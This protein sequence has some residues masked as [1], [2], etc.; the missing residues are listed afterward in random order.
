MQDGN[1]SGTVEVQASLL[2]LHDPTAPSIALPVQTPSAAPAPRKPPAR[3]PPREQK[4]PAST[5]TAMSALAGAFR[6][7][8]FY[9][10]P[11]PTTVLGHPN[12]AEY[13]DVPSAV[14]V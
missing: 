10:V 11:I 6:T 7:M 13:L 1:G 3:L 2:V 4:L 8:P 9:C 14:H 5:W 12:P